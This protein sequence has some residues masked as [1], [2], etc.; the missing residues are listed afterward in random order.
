M[1]GE[2][3]ENWQIQDMS[4]LVEHGV[5][6]GMAGECEVQQTLPVGPT[7]QLRRTHRQNWAGRDGARIVGVPAARGFQ[8]SCQVSMD[9]ESRRGASDHDYKQPQSHSHC[10]SRMLF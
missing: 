10:L 1:A 2:C 9:R 7:N 3:E 4:E 8:D 6:H 5:C